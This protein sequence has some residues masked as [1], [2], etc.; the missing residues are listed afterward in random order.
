MMRMTRAKK[1]GHNVYNDIQRK[2]GGGINVQNKNNSELTPGKN[3]GFLASANNTHD[4]CKRGGT[5]HPQ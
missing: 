1:G 4:M 5:R 3:Q 2:L